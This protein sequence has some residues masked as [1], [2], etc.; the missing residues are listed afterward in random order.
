MALSLIEPPAEEPVGLAEAKAFARID[1][2]EDDWLVQSLIVAA[3]LHVEAQT[4]SRLVTQAWRLTTD[5]IGSDG[6]LAIPLHPLRAVTAVRQGRP[7]APAEPVPA[8]AY[9]IL[10]EV[11][12]PA[13]R[14]LTPPRPGDTIEIDVSLGFGD[15]SDV[16]RPLVQ[17]ILLLVARW[18]EERAFAGI[19]TDAS[20]LPPLVMT[21]LAPYRPVAL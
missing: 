21:L 18:Y 7:G 16:P 14:L 5:R 2:A 4:R 8:S 13:L 12:H 20:A 17:A 15:P 1:T 6:R 9:V 3:R 11:S 19:G 10:S